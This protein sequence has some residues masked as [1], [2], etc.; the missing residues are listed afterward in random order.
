MVVS[1][2]ILPLDTVGITDSLSLQTKNNV[3]DLFLVNTS[4]F[5]RVK[6]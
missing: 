4:G 1:A 5:V 3:N 6:F 2:V